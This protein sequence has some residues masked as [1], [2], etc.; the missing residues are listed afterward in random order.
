MKKYTGLSLLDHQLAILVTFFA[1]LCDVGFGREGLWL[2]G[3]FGLGQ[4]GGAWT[5]MVMESLRAGN[6]GLVLS[7]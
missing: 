2:F 6:R 1:P 7:L 3:L 4:F 5:V